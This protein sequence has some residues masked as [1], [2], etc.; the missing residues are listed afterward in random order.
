MFQ[1]ST[2]LSIPPVA[3]RH[4]GSAKENEMTTDECP[5]TGQLK[6]WIWNFNMRAVGDPNGFGGLYG[7]PEVDDHPSPAAS[8]ACAVAPR[9]LHEHSEQIF[10]W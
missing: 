8:Q 10:A 6:E 2:A 1:S 5:H 4:R 3:T 9:I 7:W